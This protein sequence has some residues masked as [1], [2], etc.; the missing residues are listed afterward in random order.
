[1][2]NVTPGVQDYEITGVIDCP[3]IGQCSAAGAGRVD[4][5]DGNSYQVVWQNTDL[6]T[7]QVTLQ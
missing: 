7:C 2:A 3:T 5:V 1:M 4:V 6:G